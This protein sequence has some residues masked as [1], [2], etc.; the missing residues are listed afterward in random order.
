VDFELTKTQLVPGQLWRDR[1]PDR[2][3]ARQLLLQESALYN[4]LIEELD[5]VLQVVKPGGDR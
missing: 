2:A 3:D 5:M 1:Y 4:N